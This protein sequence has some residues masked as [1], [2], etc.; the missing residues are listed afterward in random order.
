MLNKTAAELLYILHRSCED[1]ER[2]EIKQWEQGEEAVFLQRDIQGKD[3]KVLHEKQRVNDFPVASVMIN[4]LMKSL[5]EHIRERHVLRHKLF[6]ANFL[7]T[8]SGEAVVSNAS[9]PGTKTPPVFGLRSVFC[10][11]FYNTIFPLNP[12]SF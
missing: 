1:C 2:V 11:D 6:Q 4:K 12:M 5:L 8:L 9:S 7:T 10:L 3:G